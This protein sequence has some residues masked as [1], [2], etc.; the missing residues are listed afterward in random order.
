[1]PVP[2]KNEVIVK[3][4]CAGI[5]G[6]DLK[7]YSG[8]YKSITTRIIMGYVFSGHIHL[9]GSS[10]DNWKVGEHV[11]ALTIVSSCGKCYMCTTER[12][13]LCDDKR[14]I[15]FDCHGSFAEYIKV[16]VNQLHR[17]PNYV[18]M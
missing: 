5:C 17:V 3:V 18:D 6:A 9:L 15:G 14:R 1:M 2:E 4:H 7:I 10:V 16:N 8:H 12:E 13:N 11:V